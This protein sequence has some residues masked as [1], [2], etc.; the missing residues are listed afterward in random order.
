MLQLNNK[1]SPLSTPKSNSVFLLTP[2]NKTPVFLPQILN[3][4]LILSGKCHKSEWRKRGKNP[5]R[6]GARDARIFV[7]V[8]RMLRRF[9]TNK[10]CLNFVASE[11][12]QMR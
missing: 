2:A 10:K 7:E 9:C 8:A 11:K 1:K 6:L 5:D 12:R 4:H 3:R